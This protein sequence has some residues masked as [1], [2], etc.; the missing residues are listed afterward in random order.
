[1]LLMH[2]LDVRKKRIQ[3]ENCGLSIEI[4]TNN[5]RNIVN[6][7]SSTKPFYDRWQMR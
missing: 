7:M 4:F 2:H 6:A 5:E 3:I 1:M